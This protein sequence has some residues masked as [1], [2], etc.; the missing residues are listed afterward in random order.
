M[1]VRIDSTTDLLSRT[2]GL[3]AFGSVTV[4]FWMYRT[5]DTGGVEVLWYLSADSAFSAYYGFYVD[6][7][8]FLLVE[9]TLGGGSDISEVGI[10]SLGTWHRMALIF[11]NATDVLEV[12]MDGVLHCTLPGNTGTFTPGYEAVG[13][14]DTSFFNGRIAALKLWTAVLTLAEIEMEWAQYRP[15]RIANLHR[16]TPLLTHTDLVD[17]SGVA[18]VP[19]TAAG[20]L[21]TEDGPPIAWDQGR[22]RRKPLTMGAAA[23][24]DL[25]VSLEE[26]AIL[27]STF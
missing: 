9:T 13:R 7:S 25:A 20:T 10:T 19:W 23:A 6:P 1:A 3:P 15:M 27:I 18:G 5:V 4:T 17:Y 12:Y 22:R 16:F 26:P 21:T 8:D 14:I 24:P 11:N 2:T